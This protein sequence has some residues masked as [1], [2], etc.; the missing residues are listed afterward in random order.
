MINLI[1][2]IVTTIVFAM[3]FYFAISQRI[4]TKQIA[5]IA[6][7]LYY[8]KER[9]LDE[10]NKLAELKNLEQSDGFIKFISQSRDWAFEYIEEVQS[11]LSQF[12][13][14]ILPIVRWNETYGTATDGGTYSDKIKQISLAYNKLKELLPKDIET[15]NN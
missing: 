13:A 14:D 8:D 2:Y 1:I 5:T 10:L 4:K 6:L 7:Q 9:I 11:A 15:P 12:D 3:L